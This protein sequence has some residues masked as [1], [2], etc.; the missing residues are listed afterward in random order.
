MAL[1]AR[2]G[3]GRVSGVSYEGAAG[4]RLLAAN[5]QKMPAELRRELRPKLRQAAEPIRADAQGRASWSSRIPGSI[6]ISTSFSKG[7]GGGVF[8]RANA[9]V[10]PHARPYEN[11]GEPGTF[12]HPVFGNR[13]V[14][15]PQRARPFL[16]PAVRAGRDRIIGAV[17]EA[18]NDA[19]G[20]AGFN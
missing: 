4:V 8:L 6:K 1:M 14:W 2:R 5:F 10:A 20:S 9:A 12:R 16:I 17:E 18:I 19:A 13:S 15:V 3:K 7:I 11:M